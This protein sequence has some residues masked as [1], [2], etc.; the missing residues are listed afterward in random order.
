MLGLRYLKVPSTTYVM[1]YQGGTLKREGA[2]LSFFYFAPASVIVQIPISS[3][4]IPFAFTE[5]SSDFQEVTVQGNIT[6]RIAEPKQLASL[7]D[8][9]VNPRGRYQSDDPT[10]LSERLV[11]SAKTAARK[12]VQTHAL[13]EVLTSAAPLT[14]SISNDLVG[15]EI[16]AQLGVEIMDVT[17]ASLQADAEMAKA[18]QSEAREQLLKE[19]DEAIY[20]RRNTAVEL[21]RT[22]REN[23]LQTEKMVTERK[24][25]IRE[26]EMS[27]EIA[28]E[29]QRK[30]LVE[31]NAENQR[32]E[33]AA[34]GE[35]LQALLQPVRDID[36]RTLLAMQG[37][38]DAS[39]MISSAFDNLAQGADRI[40]NLNITPDLLETLI[41]PNEAAAQQPTA[42]K[43]RTNK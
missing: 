39:T 13:R 41:K 40:G 33:S 8:Y 21:E 9:S 2:G 36:W 24:R 23:E 22:I 1:Q 30:T 11:Q 26:A 17:V 34:R 43:K 29:E 14:T 20:A 42:S 25:E 4:D 18:M 28:V 32:K 31:I 5:V 35:S 19:A 12:F 15:S 3:V 27:A 37:S 7:L 38:A 10:R 6:Y 16:V